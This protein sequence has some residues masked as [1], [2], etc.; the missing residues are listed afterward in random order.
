MI[1]SNAQKTL[2]IPSLVTNPLWHDLVVMNKVHIRTTFGC[3]SIFLNISSF[4]SQKASW[5]ASHNYF[6][7][8]SNGLL[9]PFHQ[10]NLGNLLIWTV[11][12]PVIVLN[13]I[14]VSMRTKNLS[15][16]YKTQ[17]I[18][19]TYPVT[20]WINLTSSFPLNLPSYFFYP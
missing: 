20:V 11:L 9:S 5:S 1:V 4:P 19:E 18:V 15:S 17:Y 13:Y 12:L 3:G 7:Q 6:F 8:V 14:F 10:S 16:T 2:G